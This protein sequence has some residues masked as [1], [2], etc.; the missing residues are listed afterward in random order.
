MCF[1]TGHDYGKDH[2]TYTWITKD[3]QTSYGVPV[4]DHDDHI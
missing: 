4:V 1:C 2:D 3:W